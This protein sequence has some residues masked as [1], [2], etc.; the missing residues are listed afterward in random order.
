MKIQSLQSGHTTDEQKK[1]RFQLFMNHFK[2]MLNG[3]QYIECKDYYLS[4]HYNHKSDGLRWFHS[5]KYKVEVVVNQ[6]EGGPSLNIAPFV[7]LS[8]INDAL[9][10]MMLTEEKAVENLEKQRKEMKA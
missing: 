10:L 5:D 1:S 2:P 7:L 8:S 9:L 3:N 6:L 4:L